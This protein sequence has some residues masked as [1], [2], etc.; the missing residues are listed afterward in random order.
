MIRSKLALCAIALG[1]SACE[2]FEFSTDREVPTRTVDRT[3]SSDFTFV[4]YDDGTDRTC[5]AMICDT[6]RMPNCEMYDGLLT[7]AKKTTENQIYVAY[8]PAEGEMDTNMATSIQVKGRPGISIM[9]VQNYSE[10]WVVPDSQQNDQLLRWMKQISAAGKIP[11]NVQTGEFRERQ[12]TVR[13]LNRIET[14][15]RNE[16]AAT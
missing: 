10:T 9:P 15:L 1:L 13:N 6:S 14:K 2:L 16:C 3:S 7:V 8:F 4:V 11:V 5:T 12:F